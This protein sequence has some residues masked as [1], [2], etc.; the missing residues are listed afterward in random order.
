MQNIV[1]R[2]ILICLIA[3][4]FFDLM[5]LVIKL[6]S[7]T[8]TAYELSFY[9]NFFSLLPCLIALWTSKRWKES[10]KVF[11]IRQ[12]KLACL[13]GLIVVVAQL[14]FYISLGKVAFATATTISYCTALFMTAFAVILLN[15]KVGI[16]RW[17]CVIVG[18]VGVLM[19]VK[20]ANDSF[21][22]YMVFPVIAAAFY[23]LTGVTAR[24][25]DDSVSTPLLNLYSTIFSLIGSFLIAFFV[26][27]FSPI[28]SGKDFFWITAMG[29]FG[30][31]A[32]LC[33]IL[34]YRMTEQ[35]NL[36]PF[37]YFGIPLAFLLGWLFF[38]EA[39]VN[40]LFPGA[41]LIVLGGLTI[42]WRERRI[43]ITTSG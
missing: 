15:E 28:E 27:G 20:P 38:D 29:V 16:I 41:I 24:M 40:D 37:T 17:A 32:V 18:F 33:L 6:L 43:K 4:V 35:S 10:G 19:V 22:W 2:A 7:P 9:R 23:A 25:I 34:S 31:I 30:G 1:I 5:G 36:A 14:T 21:S 3:T 26:G 39:P 12:W 42:I 8:Y 11:V 13:R